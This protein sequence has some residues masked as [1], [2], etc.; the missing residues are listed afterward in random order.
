MCG[1]DHKWLLENSG[2]IRGT[3][4]DWL[5]P[6]IEDQVVDKLVDMNDGNER[7][8]IRKRS[9]KQIANWIEKNL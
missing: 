5:E 9:F 2:A 4:F 1:V 7:T 6:Q 3:G 8:S